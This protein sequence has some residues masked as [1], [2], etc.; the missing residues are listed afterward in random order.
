M[1]FLREMQPEKFQLI[2]PSNPNDIMTIYM[3]VHVQQQ[4]A[5]I[6]EKKL[7]F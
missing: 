5:H 3:L 7:G 1:D 6:G 2:S 4:L